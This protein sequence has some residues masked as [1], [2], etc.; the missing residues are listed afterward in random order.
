MDLQTND[1]TFNEEKHSYV[2]DDGTVLK[3]VSKVIGSF[4]KAFDSHGVSYA[5][6]KRNV[7]PDAAD[8]DIAREKDRILAEWD[9][10]KNKAIDKGNEVLSVQSLVLP[11]VA[12]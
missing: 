11:L 10:K 1:V 5:M 4:K 7:G 2:H 3:S 9:E 8:E 6:A 12:Y